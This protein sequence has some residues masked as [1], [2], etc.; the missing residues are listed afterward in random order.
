MVKHR[1]EYVSE[2]YEQD[3]VHACQTCRPAADRAPRRTREKASGT[4]GIRRKHEKRFTVS[5]QYM[6]GA[7]MF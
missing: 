5:L 4:Q 1:N 2:C 3:K 7:K 6:L